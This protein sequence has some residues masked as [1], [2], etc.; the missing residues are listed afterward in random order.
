MYTRQI[1]KD[2]ET[3]YS[4]YSESTSD[5]MLY[6][7]TKHLIIF[8]YSFDIVNV[9]LSNL[10]KEYSYEDSK[11]KEHEEMTGFEII[12]H[13]AKDKKQYISYILHYLEYT[14]DSN[15]IVDFYNDASWICYNNS[16]YNIKERIMLFKTDV[17][18]PLCDYVIDELRKHVSLLYVLNKFKNRTMRFETPYPSEYNEWNIQNKLALYMFDNGYDVQRE[19]DISNGK[20]DFLF[21]DEE[22]NSYVIEVKYVKNKK[23]DF[24]SYI[25]QL[26]DYMN[27]L[28]SHIG[29]LCIFTTMDYDFKWTDKPNH[30]EII[31]I[32]VGNKK[33]NE[34]NSEII[35]YNPNL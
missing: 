10:K 4:R 18:K 23:H 20:P 27:K 15:Q 26:M 14:F 33:P 16:D 1:I 21:S 22:N 29:V 30:I 35:N 8:L 25:S 2:I 32:Y 17:I 19:N 5:Q 13:V 12:K 24:K 31:T 7:T 3:Y 6:Y 11:I 28:E 34:R 9:I